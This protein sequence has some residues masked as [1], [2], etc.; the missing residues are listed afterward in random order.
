MSFK[1]QKLF[2][3][4][5]LAKQGSHLIQVLNTLVTQVL[6]GKYYHLLIFYMLVGRP[7]YTWRS[8][9]FGRDLLKQ[10][11]RWCVGDG[12]SIM[13]FYDPWLHASENFVPLMLLYFLQ[14]NFTVDGLI[15]DGRWHADFLHKCYFVLEMLNSS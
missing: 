8:I 10:G 11:I 6:C 9:L 15:T 7:S 14:E 2:N 5:L 4:A 3:Q 13:A 12:K 1:N